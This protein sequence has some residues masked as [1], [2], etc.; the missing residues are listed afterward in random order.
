MSDERKRVFDPTINLGHVLTFI[1][2]IVSGFMAYGTI[3]KRLSLLEQAQLS[4]ERRDAEQDQR[5][6]EALLEIKQDLREIKQATQG[7][8]R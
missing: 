4:I 1:G 5:L 8:R 6:K 7:A 2:F 3:D